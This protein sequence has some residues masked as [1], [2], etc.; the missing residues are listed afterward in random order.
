MAFLS[1]AA[2]FKVSDR[3]RSGYIDY[4][5]VRDALRLM[6]IDVSNAAA[7]EVLKAYDD[8]PDGHANGVPLFGAANV[9]LF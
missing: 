6:G 7:V 4:V 2:A 3:N 1:A 9:T 5:K 8:E